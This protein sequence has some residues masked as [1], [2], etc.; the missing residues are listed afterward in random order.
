M[1][2]EQDNPA[3]P[4]TIFGPPPLLRGENETLYVALH[5]EV[6]RMIQPT[7]ILER[8]EVRD[9][10]D[11]IWEAQ[12]CK[13]L[14][15][16]LIESACVSALAHIFMPTFNLDSRK[17]FEAAN[18]YYDGNSQQRKLAAQRMA[19]YNITDEMILAKALAQQSGH[20]AYIDRMITSRE[21]TRNRLFSDI[22]RRR[23]AS[24]K[25][26]RSSVHSVSLPAPSDQKKIAFS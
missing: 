18:M 6:E 23:E 16:R 22:A 8:A 15:A 14:E 21:V 19:D 20:I 11:K 4:A 5:A 3:D 17:A 12:R 9:I 10:A 25:P 24:P 7:N 13:R 1:S 26:N 2:N